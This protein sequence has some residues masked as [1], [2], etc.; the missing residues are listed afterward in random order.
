MNA[1]SACYPKFLVSVYSS[2]LIYLVAIIIMHYLTMS[3]S[4]MGK[5]KIKL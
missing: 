4:S 2:P 5:S 3:K 1:V